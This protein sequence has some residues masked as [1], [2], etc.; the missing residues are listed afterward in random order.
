MC[1]INFFSNRYLPVLFHNLKGYD[2]HIIIR[3]AFKINQE[4]GD[5]EISAIPKSNDKFMSFKIGDMKFIDFYGVI[6]E[7][8]DKLVKNLYDKE[9][10]FQNFH[11]MK[12]DIMGNIWTSYVERASIIMSG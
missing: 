4:I 8:L 7:L 11:N 12:K 6:C 10:K 5:E 3:D 2:G 1:N 9:D